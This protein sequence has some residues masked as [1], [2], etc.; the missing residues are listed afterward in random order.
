MSDRLYLVLRRAYDE[1]TGP[2]VL[3]T[4]RNIN[5]E[6]TALAERAGVARVTPHVLR[7]TAATQMA[8]RG[9]SLWTIA[10]LL[11]DTSATVE[12]V[13]AKWQPEWGREAV[14]L[15]GGTVPRLH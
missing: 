4:T 12:A 2:Y 5:R 10:K 11:G 6:L 15:T 8:R 1:R 13:Y 3:D 7:H 14:E 9:V